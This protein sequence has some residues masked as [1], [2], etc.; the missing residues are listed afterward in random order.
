MIFEINLNK[1][2]AKAIISGEHTVLRGGDA[3]ISPSRDFSLNYTFEETNEAFSLQLSEETKPY[4]VLISGLIERA[5]EVTQRTPPPFSLRVSQVVPLGQ[6]LGGSAAMCV[7]V[8]RLFNC[9]EHGKQKEVFNLA[10]ELEHIFHGESSGVDIAGCLSD[11]IQIYRRGEE[12]RPISVKNSQ[13]YQIWISSTEVAASTEECI[14]DVL[15]IKHENPSLFFKLDEKMNE[16]SKLVQLG[17]ESSGIDSLKKGIS[18]ADEVFESWGL[19][20]SEM[21]QHKEMLF[22]GG[23][24]AVKPTGS[25]KGGC[26]LS[27]RIS[28]PESQACSFPFSRLI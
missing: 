5:K 16:A 15:K 26:M 18:M 13:E 19:Y 24:V 17:L 3:V 6:G 20:S 9:F 11:Q 25:G 14:E 28:D 22:A 2:F 27:L 4:D 10:K 21:A 23:A 7:L 12:P 8:A 1:I